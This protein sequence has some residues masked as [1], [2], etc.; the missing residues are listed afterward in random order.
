[1]TVTGL[2]TVVVTVMS[3]CCRHHDC[4]FLRPSSSSSFLIDQSRSNPT[5]KLT[6]AFV[7]FGWYSAGECAVRWTPMFA[8]R[9]IY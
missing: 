2:L 4:W 5:I 9:R 7:S 3:T 6:C 8:R 1:M